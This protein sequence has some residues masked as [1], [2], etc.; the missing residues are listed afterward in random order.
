MNKYEAIVV[1]YLLNNSRAIPIASNKLKPECFENGA[2]RTFYKILIKSAI[3]K[4]QISFNVLELMLKKKKYKQVFYDTFA[5]L[6]K[7]KNKK[8]DEFQY[9]L[10]Q[11]LL[12]YKKTLLIG[13]LTDAGQEIM[14]DDL[15]GAEKQLKDL[16]KKLDQASTD[17]DGLTIDARSSI[18]DSKE[19]YEDIEQTFKSGDEDSGRIKTGINYIDAI[20]GGGK[21][22][23][24]WVWAGYTSEGKTHMVKEIG[25]RACTMYGKNVLF[26]SLE[27]T[28]EEMKRMLE[29]RHIHKHKPGGIMTKKLELGTLTEEEKKLYYKSLHDWNTN[30]EYGQFKIWSPPMNCTVEQLGVKME[31]ISY[32]MHIDLVIV[33]YAELL[34]LSRFRYME[35]RLQ[36]TKKMEELKAIARTFNNNRG[37]FII[38]PHQISRVGKQNAE[39]RGYYLLSDLADS[40][41][42]ERTADL[43]GWN[44]I[45]KDLQEEGKLRIGVSKYRTGAKDFRGSELMGDFAH[46]LL[47]EIEETTEFNEP[48]L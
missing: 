11:V 26:V 20:T 35:K 42:V 12:S 24:L 39:K 18:E 5:D 16:F 19:L 8:T 2:L 36:V 40:A 47:E 23:E 4:E 43:V 29:A 25:Y 34:E 14:T 9:A 1:A 31:Q 30:K 10:R 46:S 7:Y 6:L 37:V 38:S 3:K 27:M 21:R 13:G 48:E 45:T 44:L 33:D 22:G 17:E 41:G 28:V 15:H 32:E